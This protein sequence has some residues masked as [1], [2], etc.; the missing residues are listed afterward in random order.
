MLQAY[1]NFW[2]GYVDFETPIDRKEFWLEFFGNLIVSSIFIAIS[3]L[4][5]MPGGMLFF[6]FY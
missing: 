6:S 4:I 3:F 2:K 5:G 1:K